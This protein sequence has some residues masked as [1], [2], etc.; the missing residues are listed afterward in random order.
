MNEPSISS[1]AAPVL[2]RNVSDLCG[3]HVSALLAANN[4]ELGRR[5]VAEAEAAQLRVDLTLAR[6]ECARLRGVIEQLGK[7]VDESLD[8]YGWM[9]QKVQALVDARF[10]EEVAP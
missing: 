6:N 10:P 8:Q 1:E 5:R 3:K 2:I 9:P 4:A 7:W